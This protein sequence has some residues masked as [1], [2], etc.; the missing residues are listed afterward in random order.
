MT[1][2]FKRFAIAVTLVLLA[3]GSWWL[4]HKVSEP[5]KAFDGKTRH[6]PDYIIENFNATVMNENGHQRYTLAALRLT[7]YGDDLSSDLDQPYLVQFR[8]GLAPLHT[9]AD[10]GWMPMDNSQILMTGN[11]VS[12]QGRDPQSAGGEIRTNTMKILLDK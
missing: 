8:P 6:D 3:G 2:D 5:E 11:V 1:L 12:S 7:H 4:T 10:K 9:R